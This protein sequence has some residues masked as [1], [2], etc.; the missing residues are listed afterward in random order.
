M[1]VQ[2]L[3]KV[4]T[5]RGKIQK[6]IPCGVS[7][8]NL[9]ITWGLSLLK[10]PTSFT[11]NGNQN[12]HFG[13]WIP[14]ISVNY[15]NSFPSFFFFS[16]WQCVKRKPW[17]VVWKVNRTI[18]LCHVGFFVLFFLNPFPP[19]LLWCSGWI[20]HCLLSSWFCCHSV[21]VTAVT[22]AYCDIT[23]RPSIL[24]GVP[25]ILGAELGG[26]G[27][28]WRGRLKEFKSW[29]EKKVKMENK[30]FQMT[31]PPYCERIKLAQ[32]TFNSHVLTCCPDLHPVSYLNCL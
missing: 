18:A 14:L 26:H 23:C 15:S 20:K 17:F 27:R 10:D 2:K 6:I 4:Q 9:Y 13:T 12:P 7:L 21:G 11:Q 3:L 31:N 19:P 8:F 30:I 32:G 1:V 5:V 29:E 25:K 24:H 22:S 28:E 16:F